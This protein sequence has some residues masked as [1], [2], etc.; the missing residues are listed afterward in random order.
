M[1]D[2]ESPMR[3][4]NLIDQ[5]IVEYHELYSVKLKLVFKNL[6]KSFKNF[7]ESLVPDTSS[8]DK[9][10]DKCTVSFL[11]GKKAFFDG[12]EI[13]RETYRKVSR[14]NITKRE[15]KKETARRKETAEL[16]EKKIIIGCMVFRRTPEFWE[17]RLLKSKSDAQQIGLRSIGTFLVDKIKARRGTAPIYLM[18]LDEDDVD[19]ETGKTRNPVEFYKKLG[20][21]IIGNESKEAQDLMTRNLIWVSYNDITGEELPVMRYPKGF[22]FYKT[23]F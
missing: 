2:E 1:E 16:Y 17:I 3:V 22:V 13:V 19:K 8:L 9:E 23:F 20:F 21:E 5:G 18:A 12:E 6:Y 15:F 7:M 10:V 14:R 4:H 11:L